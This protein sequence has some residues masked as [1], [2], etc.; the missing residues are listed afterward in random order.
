[1]IQDLALLQAPFL[2][3]LS[4]TQLGTCKLTYSHFKY[5][6]HL[7]FRINVEYFVFTVHL[8]TLQRLDLYFWI[9]HRLLARHTHLLVRGQGSDSELLTIEQRIVWLKS[10]AMHD[11]ACHTLWSP[12][13]LETRSSRDLQVS[14][15]HIQILHGT[16][17]RTISKYMYI[18]KQDFKTN[19]ENKHIKRK[20]RTF[21]LRLLQE[22]TVEFR[23]RSFH[24]EVNL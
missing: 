10:A 20:K 18:D 12:E 8:G 3:T 16:P 17:E 2:S 19:V 22:N 4:M 7:P 13:N 23:R 24:P 21:L 11:L 14:S 1:M 6:A 15:W 5:A 9:L